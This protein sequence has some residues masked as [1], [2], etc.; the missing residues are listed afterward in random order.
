MTFSCLIYSS[1]SKACNQVISQATLAIDLYSASAED[2]KMVFCFFDF[3]ET[4][5]SIM[6][7]QKS[8]TDFLVSGQVSQSEL[9]K[10]LIHGSLT[11]EQTLTR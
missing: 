8:V 1:L 4:N 5:V 3:H 2:L 11:I 9:E 10:A 6:K 7:T